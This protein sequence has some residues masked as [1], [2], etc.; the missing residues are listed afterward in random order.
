MKKISILLIICLMAWTGTRAQ[1]VHFSQFYNSPLVINPALTGAFN[2]EHRVIANYRS[3]WANIGKGY[4]TY[5][6]SYDAAL[7][8]GTI[9]NGFLGAG[10]Q[11]Y[12]DKAG[13]LRMGIMQ[14]N[15]S[16]AYHLGL[17]DNHFLTAGLQGG[18]S[19]R[20][21]SETDMQWDS[22]YNPL[23]ENGFDPTLPSYETMDF[24]SYGVGDFSAGML[25]T[26]SNGATNM[27]SNDMVKGNVGLA[28]FHINQPKKTFYDVM[29]KKMFMKFGLH[30]NVLVGIP[31]TNM[32]LVPSGMVFF[33]GPSREILLGSLFRFRLQEKSKYTNFVSETALSFGAH[34]RF[35]DA[36]IATAILDIKNWSVGISYDVNTS[37]LTAASRSNGGLEVSVRYMTPIFKKTDKSLF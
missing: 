19:Q 13:E 32:S 36:L 9:D 8:K 20:S 3:Q 31:N 18:F 2:A 24:K 30:S 11:F 12:A 10:L 1:D 33:Q 22:Q 29:A 25:W 35:G 21:I 27:A 17:S 16:L 7:L 15:A 37:K 6:L 34:Y 26:F 5:A 23:V 14:I 4:T 28:L